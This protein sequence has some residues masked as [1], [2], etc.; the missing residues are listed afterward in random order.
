[1]L[2]ATCSLVTGVTCCCRVWCYEGVEQH[3][4]V[5]K[6]PASPDGNGGPGISPEA[7]MF[8]FS[9]TLICICS[10]SCLVNCVNSWWLKMADQGLGLWIFWSMQR[11]GSIALVTVGMH[12]AVLVILYP[13]VCM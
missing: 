8:D 9:I 1:M 6:E 4:A 13:C 11:R 10:S 3:C 5:H 12:A 7:V 2:L